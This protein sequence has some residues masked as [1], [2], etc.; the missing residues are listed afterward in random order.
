M[1][2]EV[3]KTIRVAM[4]LRES[5]RPSIGVKQVGD[6]FIWSKASRIIV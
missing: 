1:Q 6:R 5:T 4:L 2:Q 3:K